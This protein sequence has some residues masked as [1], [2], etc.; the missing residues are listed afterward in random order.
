MSCRDCG[1]PIDKHIAQ[2]QARLAARFEPG[3]PIKMPVLCTG[4]AWK[5]ITNLGEEGP[6]PS[7]P[8]GVEE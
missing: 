3:K 7:H 1:G 2:L 6:P 5:A 4:C 8:I